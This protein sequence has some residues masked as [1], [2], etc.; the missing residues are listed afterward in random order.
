MIY[1][2]F[3]KKG[4]EKFKI[5]PKFVILDFKKVFNNVHIKLSFQQSDQISFNQQIKMLII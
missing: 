2:A 3:W 1:N 5:A 4:F